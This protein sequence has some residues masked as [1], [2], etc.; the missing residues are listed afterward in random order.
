[1]IDPETCI[2]CDLCVPECPVKA[3]FS[4]SDL[5]EKWAE[6][7]KLNERLAADWP[8]ISAKADPLPTADEFMDVDDKRALLDE[9]P[10]G[11]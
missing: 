5:P 9:S 3:I 2:D 8:V 10:G 7:T 1:M 4:D 6:Y 11:G